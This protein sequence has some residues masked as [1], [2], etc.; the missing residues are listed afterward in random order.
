MTNTLAQNAALLFFFA[1]FTLL[2]FHIYH[3]IKQRRGYFWELYFACLIVLTSFVTL[4][5]D[6]NS[7][8]IGPIH[9]FSERHSPAV[10]W[11]SGNMKLLAIENQG[12]ETVLTS[13]TAM[14]EKELSRFRILEGEEYVK[15]RKDE[16]KR[17]TFHLAIPSGKRLTIQASDDVT[18]LPQ[19]VHPLQF[20]VHGYYSQAS[21]LP[22]VRLR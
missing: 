20:G 4:G 10:R 2:A 21:E 22:P 5:T 11:M 8:Y 18:L 19:S 13:V 15:E 1:L 12:K 3:R 6:R 16:P 17:K 9:F 14:S 7:L